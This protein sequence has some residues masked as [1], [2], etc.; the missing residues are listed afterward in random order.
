MTRSGYFLPC[1]ETARRAWR[2]RA[3]RLAGFFELYA[4]QVLPRLR[5]A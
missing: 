1:E 2:R 5:E 4:G 3:S